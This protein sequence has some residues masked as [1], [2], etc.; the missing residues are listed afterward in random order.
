MDGF[1]AG[2]I[3]GLGELTK[4][5]FPK[6]ILASPVVFYEYTLVE[7]SAPVVALTII[8]GLDWLLGFCCA[9]KN[10]N[11]CSKAMVSGLGKLFAYMVL[12][13]AVNQAAVASSA[14]DFLPWIT[15]SYIGLTEVTSIIEN[16]N[17]LGI[18]LPLVRHIYKFLTRSNLGDD[19][20][21]LLEEFFLGMKKNLT[22]KHDKK[23]TEK[24]KTEH[25][26]RMHSL[27]SD[28]INGLLE[29]LQAEVERRAK[30]DEEKTI[31]NRSTGTL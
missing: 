26:Q 31:N 16:I 25:M 3:G 5:F 21:S 8:I 4:G 12:I 20:K 11:L 2:V 29:E 28:S 19:K 22:A 7:D 30:E 6:V 10:R 17:T 27:D 14:L 23:K 1:L 9:I 18:R 15:Y 24:I 13:I